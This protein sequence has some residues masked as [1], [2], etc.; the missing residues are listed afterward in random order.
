MDDSAETAIRPWTVPVAALREIA[1]PTATWPWVAIPGGVTDFATIMALKPLPR[2]LTEDENH[3]FDS[4]PH[5]RR[6]AHLVAVGWDDPIDLDVGLMGNHDW[7]P[8]V[9]G[10]HRLFAAIVRGDEFIQVEVSG[11][12]DLAVELLR[13]VRL[14]EP[15]EGWLNA[16]GLGPD[17]EAW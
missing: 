7:W 8:V 5:L 2:P 17:E 1:D 15:D 13:P 14:G 3:G 4:T 16:R 11:D 6:I 9:D 12:Q 10:N